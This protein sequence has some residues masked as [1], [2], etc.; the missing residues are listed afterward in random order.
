MSLKKQAVA[1]VKWSGMSMVVVT[2]L[3]FIAMA[4]LARLL[5]PSDFGLMGMVMVVIGFARAFADMGV[6]N[7]IIHRQDV[8]R[9]QLSSLYWLNIFAGIIVFCVTCALTPSIAGFYREPRLLN[10]LYLT[11]TIFLV[12]PFGQQFQI[13]LQKELK[14]NRLTKIEITS[15]I[16]NSTVAI[17]CA[18]LSFGVFSLILGQLAGASAKVA[19]LINT[20]WSNWRPGFHFSKGDLEGY[21]SFG[22]YQM[23]D[24]MV[25]Y[26]NS[27]LDYLLIG[28]MF[29]AKSLG[30]YTLAY[31]LIIRPS[32]MINPVI[33][34]VAFPLFSRIQ[35]ELDLLKRGYLKTLQ[36]LS[37][38][39]FPM[40]AGLAAVAPAAV[41]VIFGEQW[42]PS[43]ILIQILAIVGLLRSTGNPV[44][45]LVLAKGRADLAFKFNLAF[46][47]IH[48]PGLYFGAKLGGAT[49]LAIAFAILMAIDAILSYLIFIRTLIGPCLRDYIQSMWPS[50]WMST[51]MAVTVMV[52]GILLPTVPLQVKLVLQILCGVATYTGLV[53]F[54]Q[55]A[56]V[57]EIKSMIWG[58]MTL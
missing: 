19:L 15:S 1:G 31:S 20:G 54:S 53:F 17:A 24:K 7:A 32:S 23:G 27:N 57:V 48:I 58:K 2:I 56:L 4:I 5:S 28:A 16:A 21:L 36:M 9:D 45:S 33:T 49:G 26:L 41:P 40:M 55:R 39:N 8:T 46:T 43:V 11:A 10:L 22:L 29:G 30:Y 50:L 38:V 13:L 14:F 25:H 42:L 34:K 3:Q 47:V 6:S 37:T 35:N 44:G 51:V 18:F 52:S 12:T